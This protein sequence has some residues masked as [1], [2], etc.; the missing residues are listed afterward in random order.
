MANEIP[1]YV[2]RP[3]ATG[4]IGALWLNPYVALTAIL[5]VVSNII[6]WGIY[7]LVELGSKVI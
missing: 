1:I 6:G 2:T 7:G 5:V 4:V 3:N